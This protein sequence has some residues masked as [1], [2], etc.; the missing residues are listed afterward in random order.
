MGEIIYLSQ[1]RIHVMLYTRGFGGSQLHPDDQ[2]NLTIIN[3]VV[4]ELGACYFDVQTRRWW[5]HLLEALMHGAWRAPTVL[6]DS[7]VVAQGVVLDRGA[8]R[9]YLARQI[10]I[11]RPRLAKSS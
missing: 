6:V 8:L 11:V 3:G 10:T 7:T 5:T 2:R 1:R 9:A 4:K